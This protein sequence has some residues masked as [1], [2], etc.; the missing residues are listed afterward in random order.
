MLNSQG[1]NLGC[2]VGIGITS[3]ISSTQG[4]GLGRERLRYHTSIIEYSQTPLT[5]NRERGWNLR[6]KIQFFFK[7]I[8]SY[9][10]DANQS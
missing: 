10:N 4:I 2:S 7:K 6:I 3:S 9:S 1:R 8:D 5:Q